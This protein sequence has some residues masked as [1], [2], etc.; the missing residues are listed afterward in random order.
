MYFYYKNTVY[1]KL[2]LMIVEGG[3]LF[4]EPWGSV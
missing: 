2:Y 4:H 3:G 1:E